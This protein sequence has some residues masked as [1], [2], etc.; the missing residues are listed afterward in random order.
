MGIGMGIGVNTMA[1]K[2]ERMGRITMID[3]PVVRA[4]GLS[5]LAMGEMTEVG[6]LAL[7]GEIL[8]M[9]GGSGVLQV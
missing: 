6:D 2:N 1:E 4:S 3:G 7:V 9:G 8:Q 5:R